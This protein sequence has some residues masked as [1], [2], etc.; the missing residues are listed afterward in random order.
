MELSTFW[1][2]FIEIMKAVPGTVGMAMIILAISLVMGIGI[3]LILM[4]RVPLLSPLIK[5]YISFF[6]G[7]P[8]LVQLFFCYYALPGW[9]H[10][11][12]AH[13]HIA[14]DQNNLSPF[15]VMIVSCSLY[16]AAY[17]QETVRAAFASVDYSQKELADSLGYAF[18]QTLARVIIPQAL[19]Y[20]LPNVF[21]TF[22][23]IMKALSLGFTIA[24][25]DIFAQSKLLGS[26]N[27]NY[28]LSFAAAALVYWIV[29][30][31]ISKLLAHAEKRIRFQ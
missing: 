30:F 23:S 15:A 3:A 4:H 20:A 16:Y 18:S 25:I 24:V 14:W 31:T 7:T 9:I 27:G 22:L 26:L 12:L 19:V 1:G 2:F 10:S 11:L 17:Q 28:L 8:L 21:N 6:R 13:F 29:C 5:I